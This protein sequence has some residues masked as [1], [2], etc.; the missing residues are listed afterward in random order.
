[1]LQ[2]MSPRPEAT[3]VL[4]YAPALSGAEGNG[5]PVSMPLADVL[6]DDDLRI[7]TIIGGT[8]VSFAV[9]RMNGEVILPRVTR[10]EVR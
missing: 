7:F 9:A 8:D 10:I 2:A 1:V 5:E 3:T 6:G 4:L